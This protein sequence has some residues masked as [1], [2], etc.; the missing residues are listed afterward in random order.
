MQRG[1][2]ANDLPDLIVVDGG[3]PQLSAAK[4]AL[5]AEGTELDAVALAKKQRSQG[6]EKAPERIFLAGQS[7]ALVP[8]PDAPDLLLLARLRDEA[9]RFAITY[10]KKSRRRKGMRSALDAISGIGEVRKKVLLRRFGSVKQIAAASVEDLAATRGIGLK[11]ARH[12]KSAL[13][14]N[15]EEDRGESR[16]V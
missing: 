12:I 10:Q 15:S 8:A 4:A 11:M 13:R 9:H 7:K 6:R 1:L 2:R 14:E 5:Q 16:H 3:R